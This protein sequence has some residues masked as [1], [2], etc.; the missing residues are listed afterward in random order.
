VIAPCTKADFN[1]IDESRVT[2]SR[3]YVEYSLPAGGRRLF[4]RA[5][6]CE[7]TVVSSKF[8]DREGKPTGVLP[9]KLVT[10]TTSCPHPICL[11]VVS[12]Q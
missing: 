8:A 3:P 5:E 12:A 10:G 2:F 7:A 1:I 6:G 9:G 11:E 4:L